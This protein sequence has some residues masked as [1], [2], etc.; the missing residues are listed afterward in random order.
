[1]NAQQS[2]PAGSLWGL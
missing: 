2:L 1:L